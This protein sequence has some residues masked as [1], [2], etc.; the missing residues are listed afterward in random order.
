MIFKSSIVSL[1]K[2]LKIIWFTDHVLWKDIDWLWANNL[3]FKMRSPWTSKW[4]TSIKLLLASSSM[5]LMTQE[6]LLNSTIMV[7][8]LSKSFYFSNSTNILLLSIHSKFYIN[9]AKES[10]YLRIYWQKYRFIWT[11]TIISYW[12]CKWAWPNFYFCTS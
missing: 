7:C 11:N 5:A 2:M 10:L 3:V 8:L 9:N 4:R 12:K 6:I 1:I